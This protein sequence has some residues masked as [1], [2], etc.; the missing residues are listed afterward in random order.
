MAITKEI[1]TTCE[2]LE[3]GQ[4]QVKNRTV[5]YEDGI[6]ISST[7]HRHVVDVG[8]NVDNEP[9][10]VQDVAALIH[11]PARLAARTAIKLAAAS[12]QP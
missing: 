4:I 1:K 10:L 3:D 8:D 12:A 9:Q 6:E 7:N 5:I 11:T 2:V